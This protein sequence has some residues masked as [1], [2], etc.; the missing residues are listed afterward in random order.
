V[1]DSQAKTRA[2]IVRPRLGP[3]RRFVLGTRLVTIGRAAT[4][5]I[6]LSDPI[7]SSIHARIE[8]I[9]GGA[10]YRLIDCHSRNGT[11]INGV[12]ATE[13]ELILGDKIHIGGTELTY[14]TAETPFDPTPRAGISATWGAPG[15][16]PA[17]QVGSESRPMLRTLVDDDTSTM[18]VAP[19]DFD[20]DFLEPRT[21]PMERTGEAGMERRLIALYRAAKTLTPMD[22]QI[23]V[24]GR[25]VKLVQDV[26]GV[27]RVGL[28]RVKEGSISSPADMVDVAIEVRPPSE[29][30]DRVPPEIAII[31]ESHR[32]GR[33]LL[34]RRPS[35]APAEPKR[36]SGAM[37]VP[38]WVDADPGLAIYA[39]VFDPWPALVADDLRILGILARHAS[40]C[41]TNARLQAS[42]RE[43]NKDLEQRAEMR[44]RELIE[45]SKLAAVGTLAAGIAHEFNNVLAVIMGNAELA[46]QTAAMPQAAQEQL[47]TIIDAA[48]R[49]KEV[50]RHLLMFARRRDPKKEPVNLVELLESTIRL[51]STEL[52]RAG[53]R[54][55]RS[56]AAI[57]PVMGDAGQLSLVI[58]NLLKN[59]REAIAQKGVGGE[60]HVALRRTAPRP[61]APAQAILEV[62][63]TGSGMTND[64]R[65][66][67]FEPFFTTKGPGTNTGLGLSTAYGIVMNHGGTI[68]VDSALGVGSTFR[69]ILPLERTEIP[70]V[71]TTEILGEEPAPPD[72]MALHILV[73]DDDAAVRTTL[74]AM[75]RRLKHH[76]TAVASGAEA[77]KAIE[78]AQ[79]DL[80]LA[81]YGMANMDGVA[82]RAEI[83]KRHP[84]QM[85]VI[86]TGNADI[87]E[88]ATR[89]D[90]PLD[91][92]V[93]KPFSFREIADVVKRA[94]TEK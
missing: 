1:D 53:V 18:T 65:K 93:R 41:I 11:K 29:P 92:F 9:G 39:D 55:R 15:M 19:D 3:P 87:E 63:D 70:E 84:R 89:N 2:L 28:F 13:R 30:F 69:V 20:I 51:M 86:I 4:A 37:I 25:L 5:D 75:V 40:T 32:T 22:E 33:A 34:Y 58:L 73:V 26:L 42:M 21:L 74:V 48:R 94:A 16:N 80:V 68:E 67:I 23:A 46:Q 76:A 12:P 54:L 62:R 38:L 7:V 45:S 35:N 14:A 81:D 60:V 49:S 47:Q 64:V 57:P 17:G 27:M 24:E 10:S 82:L 36:P 83:L 66:H 61:D 52:T 79:F 50:V 44:S 85:I 59:A 91:S 88:L 6:V 31:R 43:V 77:I 8:P 56:L 72:L 78:G 90:I 71:S